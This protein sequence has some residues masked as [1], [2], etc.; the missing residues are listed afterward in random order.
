MIKP[1]PLLSLKNLTTPVFMDW[2]FPLRPFIFLFSL[3]E[4]KKGSDFKIRA[5]VMVI[6]SLFSTDSQSRT[7]LFHLPFLIF[8]PFFFEQSIP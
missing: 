6:L 1:K 4:L 7:G 2:V 3:L 8:Y 5:G